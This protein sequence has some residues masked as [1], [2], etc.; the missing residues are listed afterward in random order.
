MNRLQF[1][2]YFVMIPLFDLELEDGKDEQTDR[3]KSGVFRHFKPWWNGKKKTSTCF[4]DDSGKSRLRR[5]FDTE[6]E[7]DYFSDVGWDPT[8]KR[9]KKIGVQ[10]TSVFGKYSDWTRCSLLL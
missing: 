5:D 4:D 3:N 2:D 9:I 7:E 10:M 1:E 8:Q 6:V